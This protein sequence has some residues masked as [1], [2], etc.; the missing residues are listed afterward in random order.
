MDKRGRLSYGPL[1]Q[2]SFKIDDAVILGMTKL[3]SPGV[4]AQRVIVDV[5]R[6]PI[7]Q[8]VPPIKRISEDRP[9]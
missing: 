5:E 9:T 2:R 1:R 4:Q 7:T 3:N 6:L 8:A